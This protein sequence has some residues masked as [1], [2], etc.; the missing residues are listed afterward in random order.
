MSSQ[1]NRYFFLSSQGICAPPNYQDVSI[2]DLTGKPFTLIPDNNVCIHTS[3]INNETQNELKKKAESFL[4]YCSTSNITVVSGYGL[5]E[6]SSEPVTLKFNQDKFNSF[7]DNFWKEL[8][9]DSRDN[10]NSELFEK[11][12]DL[13]YV[14][15]PLYAYLLMI[16]LILIKR[17]PSRVNAERNIQDLF[18]FT[19]QIGITLVIPWQFA[20]AVFG[21]Y[22]ELNK[23]I[24]PKTKKK[25]KKDVFKT[26]WGAAWDLFYIQLIH[27]HNGIRNKGGFY[28]QFILVTDDESCSTIGSFLNVNSALDYGDTIYNGVVMNFDFPHLRHI[29]SYLSDI[30]TQMNIDLSKRAIARSSESDP[31]RKNEEIKEV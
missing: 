20:I 21:G 9:H 11:V 13:K 3:D 29:S 18:N 10:K 23:L 4:N 5:I 28:H 16:R 7:W 1:R 14:L 12:E 15:H 6:R 30:N 25:V 27:E 19:N 26:L 2:S 8:G 31:E 17:S 22:T 24:T